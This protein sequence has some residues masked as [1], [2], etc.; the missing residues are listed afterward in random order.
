MKD[1]GEEVLM[2]V[3]P[4]SGKSVQQELINKNIGRIIATASENRKYEARVQP[5]FY[6]NQY[7][8]FVYERFDDVRLVG[9]PPSS[10]GNFG[11]DSDN[12]IWPR[13]TG[14]FSIFRVYANKENMPAD[15][16]VENI[17]YKPAKFFEISMDGVKK[18]DFTMILG[19][20]GS[21]EQFLHSSAI[22]IMME[23]SLPIRIELRTHRMEI[24]DKYMNQSDKVRIQYSSKYRGVSNAWKMWQGAIL[25]L[26]RLDAVNKKLEFESEFNAWV[27]ESAARMEKYGNLMKNFEEIYVEMKVYEEM[28][29]LMREAVSAVE[30][31]RISAL[32]RSLMQDTVPADEIIRRTN[33][34]FKDY[35]YPIDQ[36]IFSTA[37]EH[38]KLYGVKEFYPAFFEIVEKKYN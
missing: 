13:H 28:N 26:E 6:G 14:D 4:A 32:V 18:D 34:L 37:L 5:M 21:T 17:P 1:V 24:M 11:E 16:S 36:E 15:Y 31:F 19:Y 7:Y 8:L 10:I 38:Y 29:D 9:A 20:P 2:G 23:R 12:W 3:D 25:G 33:G 30:I 22:R 35:Y 27:Q